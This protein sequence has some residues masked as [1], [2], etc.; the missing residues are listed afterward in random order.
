MGIWEGCV[1]LQGIRASGEQAP[2]RVQENILRPGVRFSISIEGLIG[3]QLEAREA[4]RRGGEAGSHLSC[5]L[6][7]PLDICQG[8]TKGRY[9]RLYSAPAGA[10]QLQEDEYMAWCVGCGQRRAGMHKGRREGKG[11]GLGG[12]G[13]FGRGGRERLNPV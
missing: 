12:R 13:V 11:R 2:A 8:R 3:E 7:S 1:E 5:D 6:V 4:L 9:R 10:L